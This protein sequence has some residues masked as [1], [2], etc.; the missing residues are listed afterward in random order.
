MRIRT[1]S[2]HTYLIWLENQT[3][4]ISLTNPTIIPPSIAP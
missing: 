3:V 2:A 4:L 1:P